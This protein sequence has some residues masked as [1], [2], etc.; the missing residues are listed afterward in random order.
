MF[1]SSL[2]EPEES[3]DDDVDIEE[4]RVLIKG[5]HFKN[6]QPHGG[7]GIAVGCFAGSGMGFS[8]GFGV[9]SRLGRVSV[10]RPS[11]EPFAHDGVL[12]G[13]FCGVNFGAGF[14][15][16]LARGLG[17]AWSVDQLL[18]FQMLK[19]D[20][21]EPTKRNVA[22]TG[23]ITPFRQDEPQQLLTSLNK[24]LA[25]LAQLISSPRKVDFFPH[26]RMDVHPKRLTDLLSLL[27]RSR[28][29]DNR[30]LFCLPLDLEL[31]S[32]FTIVSKAARM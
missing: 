31:T 21:Y 24:R 19:R 11:G 15:V 6:V 7:A 17:Y 29:A 5:L 2:N 10:V 13:G 12:S 25:S 22:S 4:G 30:H 8:I 18:P 3:F 16:G 20:E 9:V 14:G 32:H 27:N 28:C 26:Q 1:P 23:W